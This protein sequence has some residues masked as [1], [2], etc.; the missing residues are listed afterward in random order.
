MATS[1]LSEIRLSYRH[2]RKEP[3]PIVQSSADAYKH[4]L[5][6]YERN[7]LALQ[8]QFV[9]LYL[10]RANMVLGGYQCSLGGL[11]GTVVD[12][13]LILG[14]ALKS[15]ACAII[16]SHNHPS[17]NLNPSEADLE[18]TQRLT[19]AAQIM[20]IKLLDHLIL[21]PTAGSYYSFAD[22]GHL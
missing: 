19:K 5:G 8:E 13:R 4:L 16:I 17:G 18:L 12:I 1:N 14:V 3:Q 20:D 6:F 21:S 15:S 7:T 9:I 22:S 10:N 11:T 2:K